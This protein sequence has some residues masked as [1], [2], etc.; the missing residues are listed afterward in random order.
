[1]TIVSAPKTIFPGFLFATTSAFSRARR[2]ACC[3]GPS[4]RATSSEI[5]ATSTV[6]GMPALR[7]NSARRGEA[8]A[9]TRGITF[10][11]AILPAQFSH[12]NDVPNVTDLALGTLDLGAQL[13]G[14]VCHFRVWA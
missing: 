10:I 3:T 11:C 9:R 12:L 6:K 14:S 5:L 7:N 13:E 4:P 2:S 1:M 8:E